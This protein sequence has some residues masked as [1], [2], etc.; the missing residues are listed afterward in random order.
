MLPERGTIARI[1]AMLY[2][3]AA[4]YGRYLDKEQQIKDSYDFE[5][6]R[7]I[8][9]KLLALEEEIGGIVLNWPEADYNF[10]KEGLRFH[11]NW[12][13]GENDKTVFE[14]EYYGM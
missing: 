4:R 8:A 2:R 6:K 11:E 5:R 3:L 10:I 13:K 1:N 14:E 12:K 9:K 7:E